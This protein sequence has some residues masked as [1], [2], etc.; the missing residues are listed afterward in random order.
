M[1]TIRFIGA[2]RVAVSSAAHHA[3]MECHDDEAYVEKELGSLALVEL[4]VIGM[5]SDGAITDMKQPHTKYVPY[6]ESYF[7]PT[8]LEQIPHDLYELPKTPDFRVAFYLHFYDP[9]QPVKTPWGDIQVGPITDPPS[10]L[11]KKQYVF[12]D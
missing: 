12:W 9:T 3:A 4:E 7:H 6:D 10:H 2:Y 11:E 5:P 1:A 8:T